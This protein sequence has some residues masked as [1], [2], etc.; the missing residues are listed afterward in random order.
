MVT[1]WQSLH[2]LYL[3]ATKH[4]IKSR[5]PLFFGCLVADCLRSRL[6]IFHLYG[7]VTITGE[8]L[9]NLDVCSARLDSSSC[10]TYCDTGPRFLRSHPK[11]RPHLVALYQNQGAL[12]T[13]SNPG[14]HGVVLRRL[15]LPPSEG[16]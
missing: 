6:K 12:R 15:G 9:Q 8:G 11:P 16:V 1:S 13:Y 3:T 7:D 5:M 2:S 10:H 14:P 4:L